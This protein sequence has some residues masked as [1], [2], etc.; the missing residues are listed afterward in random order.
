ML[1]LP[2]LSGD[3]LRT[4]REHL[5][6]LI[7]YHLFFTLL[8]SSLLLPAV[9]WTLSG[10]LSQFGRPVITNSELIDLLMSPGGLLWLL[11]AVG[12]TFLVLYLQQSGMILVAVRP[13]DHHV[14]LA[15]E[16]LWATLRRLPAISG[17]VVLQV[18]SQLLLLV[19]LALSLAWLHDFF[20][21][22]LDPY[23]VQNMRPPALWA[24]LGS[25]LIP[26]LAWILLAGTLYVRWHLALP[27][28]TLEGLS[29]TSALARS[30]QLT[31][32]RGHHI[33]A[34]VVLLLLGIVLLPLLAT[35]LFDWIV[36]PL[37][38]WLP[39]RNTVL[40]PAMLAYLTAYLL[41]ALAIT[42]GGIAANA[43]QATCLYL[44][45]AHRE[46]RP[47][48]PP[49]GTHPGRLA[50][51]VELAV[52][53]FAIGQAWLIVNRFEIRD[54]VSVIA[55][56]GSSLKA[57]ENTMAAV[58]QAI[59]DRSDGIEIDVR[60][61]A[62]G[63]VVLYHDESLRRLAG[64]NRR[65]GALTR[66]ELAEVDVGSWF[67]DPFIGEPIPGLDEV[68][69]T[70]RG[71]ASLM[72]ELKPDPGRELEL[73]DA[74]LD[75]LERERD[76]RRACRHR[77][78]DRVTALACGDPDIMRDMFVAAMSPWLL[79]EATRREPQLRTSLLAQLVMSGT[80]ERQGFDA[81][82]L[83]HNRIDEEEVRLAGYYGYELHAWTINDRT[84]MSQLI[85]LGV[86][87]IITDRPAM[88]AE[89]IA[90]RRRLGDGAVLLV[91]LRN[92]L[93]N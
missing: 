75:D 65:V 14:R 85:D 49:P 23:F 37:L 28:L 26:V 84:R 34:A 66:S 63:E 20:L 59:R 41:I 39:E 69:A 80:L 32:G 24:F 46:P 73:V 55:H 93:R 36:T 18:G 82:A 11:V 58:E 50:W 79:R 4:L 61:T 30:V 19:P 8:A 77:A 47:E 27:A 64:D 1:P 17:L 44:H 83:R 48:P 89:L 12:L 70:V 67:G 45:L 57:P 15:F 51:A 52:V 74:V 72:I 56:R 38:W 21:G 25:S 9:G 86:D 87:A 6:P 90:E 43:L 42:F 78:E 71:R 53:L 31:R 10:L 88:L 13:R 91:K 3:V 68:L 76:V 62:D 60:L 22:G 35:A 2:R 40:V 29:P 33:A 54:E 5:R 16:A 92:W 81:L 7:A